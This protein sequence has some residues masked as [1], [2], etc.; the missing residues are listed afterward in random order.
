VASASSQTQIMVRVSSNTPEDI[1]H[2]AV[3]MTRGTGMTQF[4]MVTAQSAWILLH[5]YS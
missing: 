5:L 2:R 1:K 3:L 4:V